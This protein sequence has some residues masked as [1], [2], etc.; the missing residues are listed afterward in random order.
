MLKQTKRGL[1]IY[2]KIFIQNINLFHGS[3]YNYK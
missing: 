3:P 2:E 1:I